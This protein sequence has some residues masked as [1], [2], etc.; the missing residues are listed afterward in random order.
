MIVGGVGRDLVKSQPL[1]KLK[2]SVV[3]Q[4]G[5]EYHASPLAMSCCD[6]IQQ[7]L[8]TDSQILAARQY[9]NFAN[10]DA[11]GPFEELDHPGSYTIDLDD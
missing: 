11:I 9:L 2:R 5:R 1:V 10:F 4:A 8:A 6:D 3:L 7:D